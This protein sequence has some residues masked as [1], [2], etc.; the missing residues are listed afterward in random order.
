MPTTNTFNYIFQVVDGPKMSQLLLRK[1]Q[2]LLT[3]S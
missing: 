2:H 3:N 1:P